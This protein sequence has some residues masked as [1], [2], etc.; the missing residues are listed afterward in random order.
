M[1]RGR[2]QRVEGGGRRGWGVAKHKTPLDDCFKSSACWYFSLPT[3]PKLIKPGA[4]HLPP[5]PGKMIL[6][7][8]SATA[9]WPIQPQ[10]LNNSLLSKGIQPLTIIIT[11][12]CGIHGGGRH[13]QKTGPF[14]SHHRQSDSYSICR[15]WKKMG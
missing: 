4:I 9:E 2:L 15:Y 1:G 11:P 13:Y 12:F 6:G 7:E 14:T 3:L 10:S 8:I 5:V